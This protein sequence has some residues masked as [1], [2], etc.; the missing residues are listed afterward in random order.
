MLRLLLIAVAP[1]L[2]LAPAQAKEPVR[3]LL[4]G[5]SI[6]LGYAPLVKQKLG[7]SVEVFSFSTN[8]GDTETTLKNLEKWLKEAKPDVVTFNNGLHDLKFDKTSKTH[9]V[10]IEQYRKNLAMILAKIQKVTPKVLF[11]NTSPIGD[12]RHAE[13]KAAFDRFDAD[14]VK[15]NTA[16]QQVMTDNKVPIFD[17][18]DLIQKTDPEKML[19]KDGTHYTNEAKE[20]QA[21]ALIARLRADNWIPKKP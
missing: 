1:M 6:R 5:D 12:A 4:L 7:D 13:R 3:L 14:V 11:V 2:M 21:N 17:M 20:I 8:G 18:Y 9:Q 16:A 10:S 15:F 19:I